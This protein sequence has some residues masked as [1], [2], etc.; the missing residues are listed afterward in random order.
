[1]SSQRDGFR[2]LS[3]SWASRHFIDDRLMVGVEGRM[4]NYVALKPPMIITTAGGN[5]LEGVAQ[6][7]LQVDVRDSKGISRNVSLPVTLVPGIN[8]HLFSSCTAAQPGVRT[9]ICKEGSYLDLGIFTI[10]LS[11]FNNNMD[12][13]DLAISGKSMGSSTACCAISGTQFKNEA[14]LISTSGVEQENVVSAEQHP[15]SEEMEEKQRKTKE[16]QSES[17]LEC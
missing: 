8:K 1:M 6:G 7:V 2:M 13:I 15:E 14:A 9:V 4:K 16:Q 17:K 10:P 11:K 12:Y 3:D 5:K